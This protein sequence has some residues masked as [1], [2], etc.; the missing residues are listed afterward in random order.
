M[1]RMQGERLSEEWR[2]FNVTPYGSN[3]SIQLS[4][5]RKKIHIHQKSTAHKRAQEIVD[6]AKTGTLEK[7]CDKM[8]ESHL[9]ATTAI[10]RSA[11]LIAKKDRPYSDHFDN[12]ELQQLNGVD[13]GHGLHS[14]YSAAEIIDHVAKDMRKKICK[15]IIEMG[16]NISV[17]IDESTTLSAKTT[18]IIHLKCETNKN[19]DPCYLFLDLI[20]LSDQKAETIEHSLLA[21]LNSHGFDDNYLKKHLIA[22]T[23]DGASVM[24]G[25]KSGV[26]K[27][28]SDRY[29]NIIIWH[30]LNHRLELAVSDA[31]KDIGG[32][33]HFQAFMDKLYSLYSRSPQNQRELSECAQQL[34]QEVAKIGRV[35]DVRWVASSFRTVAAVWNNFEALCSHFST[36]MKNDSRTPLDR[37]QYEG[38]LK[39]LSS[40]QFLQDLGVMY[41]VLNELALLSECLQKR[42]TSIVYADKLIKRSISFIRALKE[43]PGTKTLEAEIAAREG[44]LGSVS[45]LDSRKIIGIN[46]QKF[47][48]SLVDSMSNRMFAT[49]SNRGANSVQ[50]TQCQS[51]YNELL[52]HLSVMDSDNWPKSLP[53]GYGE[54]SV[55]FL[56][57]KFSLECTATVN[58]FRDYI[59]NGGKSVPL[60]LVPLV[61]CNKLI[62]CSS[63]ECER[64][65]S[66]M[67]LIIT[68]LRSRLLTERVSA[69][70]FISQ[71]GP[72]LRRWNPEPYVR[73]WLRAHRAAE[74]TKTRVAQPV[75]SDPDPLWE[76]L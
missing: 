25:K 6:M 56:C 58:A 37:K 9:K 21:C 55:R 31:V 45:L 41:D 68:S 60:A 39:K 66:L 2:R 10:F 3:R 71:H 65:F 72:P 49:V 38:M 28:L 52:Q 26:A 19:R 47:L 15:T 51:D 54:R 40:K 1:K 29:P 36:A 13:I 20:E 53:L 8:N 75:E 32:I 46:R 35:L 27:R 42:A 11:Y 18:L 62:P 61:N 33:N 48:T 44:K 14:R 50:N 24:L 16:G 22:F 5:L 4:S 70:M 43:K 63:A 76:L 17:I 59:E 67:N 64:G 69:L 23:S 34:H 74:S 7:M 12:L 73:T 57:D 30:C